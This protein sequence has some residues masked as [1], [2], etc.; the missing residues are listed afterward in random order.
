MSAYRKLKP[1]WRLFV[2]G[3]AAG[4]KP[5]HVVRRLR[6]HLKL[7]EELASKWLA[8]ADVKAALEERL[9]GNERLAAL[10]RRVAALEQLLQ[11]ATMNVQTSAPITQETFG[12]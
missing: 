2:D 3:C 1:V 5:T 10:E 8:R 4:E 12:Q 11:A 9:D 6:P 7:P